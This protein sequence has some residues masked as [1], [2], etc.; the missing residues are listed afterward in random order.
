VLAAFIGGTV[1]VWTVLRFVEAKPLSGATRMSAADLEK[2]VPRGRP[3]SALF[4]LMTLASFGVAVALVAWILR[5]AGASPL[6]LFLV[7]LVFFLTMELPI[8][9]FEMCCGYSPAFSRSYISFLAGGGVRE[10]G[11]LRGAVVVSCLTAAVAV[12][13]LAHR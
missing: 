1:L 3:L 6:T 2:L 12:A 5:M 11:R 8:A 13:A 9:G 4:L 10:R 7:P